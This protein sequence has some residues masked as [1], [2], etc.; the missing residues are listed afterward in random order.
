LNKKF[1]KGIDDCLKNE[2]VIRVAN[3]AASSFSNVLSRDEMQTCI[4][5][6]LWKAKNKYIEG[7]KCKFTSYVH[8]G[9]VFECLT[10]RKFNLA[11]TNQLNFNVPD[12]KN[13]LERIDMLDE[14]Q[15]CDDPE[16]IYDRFYKN[17]TIK[18]IAKSRGV[19]GETI[20]IRL[21]KN[22]K[23]LRHSMSK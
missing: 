10:Q 17:M 8:R 20:R 19:C 3:K 13:D 14:I 11:K 4:L 6:A 18:E 21:K 9:V 15:Q 1:N 7:S 23:K 2:D 16:L 5:S 12:R 22:L